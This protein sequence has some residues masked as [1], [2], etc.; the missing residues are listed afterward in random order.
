[1]MKTNYWSVL[2]I[3]RNIPAYGEGDFTTVGTEQ[4]YEL[5]MSFIL[6][7]LD[8][9]V[10][11]IATPGNHGIEWDDFLLIVLD[12]GGSW[13]GEM[14]HQSSW[15]ARLKT[16]EKARDRMRNLLIP[17]NY[18]VYVF[19]IRFWNKISFLPVK[20]M[21]MILFQLLEIMYL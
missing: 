1:M 9:G 21:D 10:K 2:V 19:I 8:L 6:K 20:K 18:D 15:L 4:A 5:A 17:V 7:V 14:Y 3:E 13:N 12:F 16:D 11:I